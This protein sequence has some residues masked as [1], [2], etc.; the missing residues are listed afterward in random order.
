MMYQLVTGK[1]PFTAPNFNALMFA[2]ASGS[3]TPPRQLAPDLRPEF[4]QFIAYAMALDPN[5]RYQT[6]EH[7]AQT[8]QPWAQPVAAPPPVAEPDAPTRPAMVDEGGSRTPSAV[9][10]FA[11]PPPEL[12]TATPVPVKPVLQPRK[13]S[14]ALPIT[15]AAGIGVGVFVGL[16]IIRGTGS[17][18]KKPEVAASDVAGKTVD[19]QGKATSTTTDTKSTT[20]DTKS[21][22]TDTKPAES[23][24]DSKPADNKPA[25][26]T[27]TTDSK[28]ADS[29]T[30]TDSKPAD[31][32]P[33][34]S[35]TTTDSKPA[36]T[37][38]A[39]TKPAD[40]KPADTK[41]ADTK[42]T[43]QITTGTVTFT[44]SPPEAVAAAKITVD[45]KPIT[46][47]SGTVEWRDGKPAKVTVKAAGYHT[48]TKKID[49]GTT[50][51]DVKLKKRTGGGPGG[52]IV[53]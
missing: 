35:T 38:P 30:T 41:P 2:I 39:D 23:S 45:D 8:L 28:P 48:F 21:T 6:A 49:P 17:G 11:P 24:T 10:A 25:D 46:G 18:V 31:T 16:I 13:R 12:G 19:T 1:L 3:Y 22:T 7:L 15:I 14:K 40:T 4:E 44:I 36:D 20:T 9:K 43:P 34:D 37:K 52:K 42:P 53:L 51:V 26:S 27:T 29:T 47:T 33:A 32:K 5:H 50:T